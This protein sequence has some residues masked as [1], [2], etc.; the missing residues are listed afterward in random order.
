MKVLRLSEKR[1]MLKVVV[2]TNQFISSLI[3]RQGCSARLIE[4]WRGHKFVLIINRDIFE[5]IKRVFYYP[6]I[7]KAR[8]LDEGEVKTFIHFIEERAVI[9][10]NTPRVDVIKEDPDDNSVLACALK[11]KADYIVSG[12]WHL[13]AL[14]YY[15]GIPIVT[16]KEFLEVIK[17]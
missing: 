1:K 10:S 7:M 6:R 9:L 8:H 5:E 11:V 15:Q 16:V 12:D 17:P 13:L 2:D 4:A 3:G 14:K